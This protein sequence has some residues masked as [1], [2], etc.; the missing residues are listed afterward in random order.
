MAAVIGNVTVLKNNTFT[1]YRDVLTTVE[2]TDGVVAAE[3]FIFDELMIASAG[4]PPFGVS[5]KGVD[6][7]RVAGVLDLGAR[8][9]VGSLQDLG[10]GE[11]PAIM[12]GDALAEKLRVRA[13]DR[14]VLTAR[15]DDSQPGGQPREY[16]FRVT[17][18]FHTAIDEYDQ[19]LA[20]AALASA[21]QVVYRRDQVLGIE[22]KVKDIEQSDKV[23]RAVE[24]ALGGLPYE[25]MD[26]RE[27]SRGSSSDRKP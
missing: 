6:P 25:V 15:A 9:K 14:V 2:K 23:A 24:R 4:H 8:L 20:V 17:G 10:R 12:L 7:Q 1:E 13:G 5:L 26:W 16:P 18:I 19:R 11:P 3:P 27:L 22:L 21:Q